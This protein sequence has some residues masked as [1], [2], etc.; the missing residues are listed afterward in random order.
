[1]GMLT[2]CID[3]NIRL[4]DWKNFRDE[5]VQT[6][7]LTNGTAFN[8]MASI[9]T[10]RVAQSVVTQLSHNDVVELLTLEW[11]SL[12]SALRMMISQL[13]NVGNFSGNVRK[14][15]QR[16]DRNLNGKLLKDKEK[17]EHSTN[18]RVEN[19]SGARY[20]K[21][22]ISGSEAGARKKYQLLK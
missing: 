20:V 9:K 12:P 13:C 4:S 8:T 6:S 19:A 16:L 17:F 15:V 11:E 14:N 22:T 2:Y 3:R 10:E 7:R 21:R 18:V 1:M 5:V